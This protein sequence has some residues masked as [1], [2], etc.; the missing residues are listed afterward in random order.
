MR[1]T[2]S[3]QRR[4]IRDSVRWRGQG[5]SLARQPERRATGLVPVRA[6]PGRDGMMGD[7]ETHVHR[8]FDGSELVHTH[9]VRDDAT[10]HTHDYIEAPKA[11]DNLRQQHEASRYRMQDRYQLALR[12]I[13]PAD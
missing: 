7:Y 12:G 1:P 9:Y 4:A 8:R 5:A 11:R 2:R 10:D 6:A 13:I 3:N